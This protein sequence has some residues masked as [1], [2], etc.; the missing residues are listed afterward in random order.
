MSRETLKVI[1]WKWQSLHQPWFL[2]NCGTGLH[3][4]YP[5]NLEPSGPVCVSEKQASIV[6]GPLYTLESICYSGQ[7]PLSNTKGNVMSSGENGTRNWKAIRIQAGY[8]HIPTP[9]LSS[10]W[11]H[12]LFPLF[13]CSHLHSPSSDNFSNFFMP[14]VEDSHSKPLNLQLLQENS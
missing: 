2:S 13:H 11:D 14:I 3:C 6:R 4:C 8:F 7:P 1:C 5:D 10:L 12:S 9:T